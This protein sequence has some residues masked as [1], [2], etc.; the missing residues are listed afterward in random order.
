MVEYILY[1]IDFDYSTNLFSLKRQFDENLLEFLIDKIDTELLKSI[2]LENFKSINVQN[3]HRITLGG[4]DHS[5]IGSLHRV[6]IL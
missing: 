2:I 5:L 6:K 1:K 4:S 3:A